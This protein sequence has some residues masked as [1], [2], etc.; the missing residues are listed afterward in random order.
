MKN[1]L[2]A[3]LAL[4]TS[5]ALAAPLA[6]EPTAAFSQA[7]EIALARARAQLGDPALEPQGSMSI[8]RAK[9]SVNEFADFIV[10]FHL[11][12]FGRRG[13]HSCEGALLIHRVPFAKQPEDVI[14]LETD[15]DAGQ[16]T[17]ARNIRVRCE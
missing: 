14:V 13:S 12:A 5:S 6:I 3:T 17:V 8:R 7:Y 16:Q 9:N 1:L 10:S 11:D 15:T 4:S 2:L